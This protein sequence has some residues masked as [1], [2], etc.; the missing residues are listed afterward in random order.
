MI[1]S[2][3]F[4]M[5]LIGFSIIFLSLSLVIFLM[6]QQDFKNRSSTYP[7]GTTVNNV[8]L[9]GLDHDQAAE[10]LNLVFSQPLEMRYGDARMQFSPSELGFTPDIEATLQDIDT[11]NK[12]KQ[13]WAYLWGNDPQVAVKGTLKTNM[14]EEK[15]EA[16]FSSTILPR[17]DQPATAPYPVI[18]TTHFEPGQP[19]TQLDQQA[20]VSLVKNSLTSASDRIVD[21]PI[22]QAPPL[23]L[24][25]QNLQIFLEQT[26]LLEEFDDLI[27]VYVQDLSG[28]MD[29]H[30]ALMDNQPVLPD[31]AYSAASTIKIPIM[32]S[33]L[34]RS[35]EPTSQAIQDLLERMI[36]LSENPPADTLMS[37][38]ID[39]TRGP[40]I[41]TEDL[42][43]L[44]YQNTFLAGY[45]GMGS[46]LL[47]VYETPANTRTDI[48]LD[49]DVYN[50]TVP[51]EIG[52]LLAQIYQCAYP[53][54]GTSKISEIFRSEVSQTECQTILDL[55]GK[56]KIGVLM[57]AGLPP[58]AS[59][60]HKHG[61]TPELDGLL[62]S[63]SDAGIVSTSGG[64][65]VLVM[66]MHTSDQLVFDE[67]NW[68]F[69]KLSQTIYNAFNINDQTYW[70]IE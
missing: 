30:L 47:K 14:D 18:Y 10:R 46:P 69:A 64:D 55:L 26:V 42:Q 8:P 63:I 66:F 29:L 40:L 62:H 39:P 6:D 36:A 53:K 34:K 12:G 23:P 57:E 21:L 68:L 41:V 1:S 59:A 13:Y 7:E 51:S 19:G 17:Y 61:W 38:Y 20:A 65:Y 32:L 3:T 58:Q 22:I 48:Y 35:Q 31:V 28:D 33:V 9:G 45:F 60:A 37:S 24:D 52:D 15:L 49:P 11:N 27:E 5:I 16:F 25:V 54:T 56:N 44:G 2:R 67:G 4:R 50:Q 43:M 70:W